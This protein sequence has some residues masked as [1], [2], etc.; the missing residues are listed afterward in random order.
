MN[1]VQQKAIK[2]Q[3]NVAEVLG[4]LLDGFSHQQIKVKC[5][6]CGLHFIVCTHEP[7]KHGRLTMHC[8]EC[9]QKKG[10][11]IVWRENMKE[12]IFR[13]VPGEAALTDIQEFS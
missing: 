3:E 11:F 13:F 10:K 9:G 5:M 8:P 6:N 2:D 4:P 1:E 12:P 7:E